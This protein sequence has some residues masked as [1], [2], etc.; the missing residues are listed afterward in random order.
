VAKTKAEPTAKAKGC[1]CLVTLVVILAVAAGIGAVVSSHTST[2][3]AARSYIKGLGSDPE[4]VQAS[5]EDVLVQVGLTEKSQ[6]EANLVQLAT[7]ASQVHASL[8]NVRDDFAG[9]D[10]GALGTAEVNL[11][12]AAN[13]LKNSMGALVGLTANANPATIASFTTQYQTGHDEW[14]SAVT[15]IWHLA[16]ESNPP[17]I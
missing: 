9:L 5:V 6:T 4:T 3:S 8:N 12:D 13:Q 1:G 17:T 10:S 15:T 14:N 16:H 11:F 2:Q 7:I